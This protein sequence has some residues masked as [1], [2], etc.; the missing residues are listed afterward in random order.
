MIRVATLPAVVAAAALILV[1]CVVATGVV[2]GMQ[3]QDAEPA[4]VAIRNLREAEG[5]S[6]V[7]HELVGLDE[8][9]SRLST[10]LVMIEDGRFYRH[11]GVDLRAIRFALEVN[12]AAG[13]IVYGGSTITQQI[14]RTLFLSPRQTFV[15]KVVEAL[16][17]VGLDYSLSK[18]RILELYVNYAEWGPGV[19]GIQ[20]AA[21][22]HF[23]KDVGEL[24]TVE[25]M[26]LL[27]ILPN[28]RV[29][30]PNNY[31]EDPII[32]RR[33]RLIAYHYWA[34]EHLLR[35]DTNLERVR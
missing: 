4:S 25:Q 26:A 15:R 12:L 30:T 14:A 16:L 31:Q 6:T 1:C 20:G 28:P 5:V 3:L 34:Q 27:T 11:H 17:A 22:Y 33:Y 8:L 35:F 18:Q 29:Y 23:G 7:A 9:P 24:S 10:V 32:A 19:Y 2:L 21:R 13:R